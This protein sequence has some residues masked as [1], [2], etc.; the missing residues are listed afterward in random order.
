M[1]ASSSPNFSYLS[2]FDA[3]LVAAA[4]RAEH[5]VAIDPVGALTHLRLFGELLAQQVAARLNA[6]VGEGEH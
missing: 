3:R 5:V 1:A 4:S 6:Q 2:Y